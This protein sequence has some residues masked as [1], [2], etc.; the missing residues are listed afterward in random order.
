MTEEVIGAVLSGGR[1]R[2][3]G[4]DKALLEIGGRTLAQRAVD[5]LYL[6]GLDVAL[7]LRPE[8]PAP[9]MARTTAIVRD[10]IED[11]GPMGGLHALLR[12][13][14]AEWTL[15]VPCD[16]PFLIPA[17]LLGLLGQPRDDVDAIVGRQAGLAE[18]L[19]GLYR[20]TCLPAVEEALVSGERSLRDLLS[21]LRVRALPEEQLHQWDAQLLSYLNINTQADLA[22]ARAFAESVDG[23]HRQSQSS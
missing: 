10:E 20:R 2:R 17:L 14:P 4:G 15:V 1:G 22:R 9:L 18:P 12:W 8:Q 21:S 19:P 7:V 3:M 11:A 13:L 6:A 23:D 5:A 16:Q